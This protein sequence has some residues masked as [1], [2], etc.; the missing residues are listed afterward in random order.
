MRYSEFVGKL[1]EDRE[2]VLLME[3][4][5]GL[6]LEDKEEVLDK[7]DYNKYKIDGSKLDTSE[8]RKLK[9]RFGN[10]LEDKFG[11][12]IGDVE[13]YDYLGLKYKVELVKD[14][15][16]NEFK[17]L[18]E[19]EEGERERIKK[20]VASQEVK[21]VPVKGKDIKAEYFT[22]CKDIKVMDLE[23]ELDNFKKSF[24]EEHKKSVKSK[25]YIQ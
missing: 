22:L 1:N 5:I 16:W 6:I 25:Q 3:R 12:K 7:R 8:Q 10:E 23:K 11:D 2:R 19:Y 20:K 18:V 9:R 15:D 17:D 24:K 13:D 21:E 14:L 4:V